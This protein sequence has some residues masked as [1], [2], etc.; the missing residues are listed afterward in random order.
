MRVKG[1]KSARTRASVVP[2]SG[3]TGESCSPLSMLKSELLPVLG[4]P[5]ITTV[6]FSPSSTSPWAC[7]RFMEFMKLRIDEMLVGSDLSVARPSSRIFLG[8]VLR[9]TLSYIL[10]MRL[11]FSC[12]DSDDVFIL[13]LATLL[14]LPYC[15]LLRQALICS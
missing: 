12:A 3:E 7:F 15:E 13:L 10:I 8:R 9:N 14:F 4:C 1:P 2:A 6:C 5:T 11:R